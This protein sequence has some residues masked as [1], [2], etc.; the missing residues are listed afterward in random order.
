VFLGHALLAFA[1]AT[2]IADWRGWTARRALTLGLVAGAFAAIPDVDVA[3]A[4]VALDVDALNAASVTQ[5][6]TFW[7]ATRDVHRTMTHSLVVALLAGPAFGLWAVKRTGSPLTRAAGRG[8]SAVALAALVGA[9]Y[10]VSGPLGGVVMGMFA[11]A[12]VGVATLCRITTDFPART[13]ALAATAGLLSHPWGDLVTG[14]PPRLF[15]PFEVGV[16]DGRVLLHGDPT[17]HLLG[18]F[19]IEL[20]V[21]WLAAVAIARVAGFSMGELIDR[22]ALAGAAYG[23]AAVAMAPPTLAVSYHFVFSILSVGVVCAGVSTR[24]TAIPSAAELRRQFGRHPLLLSTTFTALTG[25]T[26]ALVGYAAV[27]FVVAA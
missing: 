9:A 25:V 14:K 16:F 27:Y 8:V 24:P 15:Y 23:V 13:V 19:A 3:Y 21:A 5:P 7:D 22:R 4:A 11:V 12:G 26:A 6:S 17:I 1:L 18:A 10:A 20:S 2:L